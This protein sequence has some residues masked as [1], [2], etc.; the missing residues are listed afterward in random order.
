MWF[1]HY[2]KKE[3]EMIRLLFKE[4]TQP[5]TFSI[6]FSNAQ[7]NLNCPKVSQSRLKVL[8]IKEK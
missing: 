4:E 1:Y 5:H 2:I 8:G 6:F 3:S 7:K